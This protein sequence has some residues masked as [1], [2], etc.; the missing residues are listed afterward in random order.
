MIPSPASATRTAFRR[1]LIAWQQSHGRHDL[2]WQNTRDPYRIW[3]SEIMLQ[4]TQVR[5]VIPR[6][7]AFMQRFPTVAALAAASPDAVLAL[8][9][10]L[11]Y[12]ARARNLHR[13]AREVMA[14]FD[15]RVPTAAATLQRLPGIG[16]STAAA[17]SVFA[18]G[19]RAAILD[20]NVKRVLCRVFMIAP[21][22][23]A[24]ADARGLWDLAERLVPHDHVEAYTQG[25]MDL[26]S[27]VCVP[28]TPDCAA[29]P[30]AAL[31][32]AHRAGRVAEFPVRPAKRPRPL[33]RSQLVIARHGD[34]V[35]LERRAPKGI[36]GGLWSL[37]E[38][39]DG[40]DVAEAMKNRLGI[41]CTVKGTA[42]PLRHEFTHFSLDILPVRVSVR[43]ARPPVLP[44]E[45]TWASRKERQV[46][47][48]PTPVRALLDAYA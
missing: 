4:Q 31:C 36:W 14:A 7:A 45:W 42:A 9:A 10:G 13:A 19:E 25:L 22:G 43:Q 23:D 2:P 20:G 17:I 5:T 11:G 39:V 24:A 48:L 8:W 30:L 12:Y 16:R 15:G 29:C 21:G 28:R 33:K 18:A 1:R 47:G 3:V 6:Y 37:P 27:G 46:L 41:V 44:G 26:G 32:G 35:L 38:V 40:A 34:R